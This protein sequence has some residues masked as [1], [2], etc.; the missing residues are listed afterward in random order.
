MTDDDA[1]GATAQGLVQCLRMLTDEAAS[2]NLLHTFA[3]LQDALA[4]CQL[5]MVSGAESGADASLIP[6]MLH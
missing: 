1:I 2:L 4:T 6:T 3:A 5:E